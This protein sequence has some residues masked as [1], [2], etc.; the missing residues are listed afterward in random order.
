MFKRS[1]KGNF[2]YLKTKRINTAIITAVFF[3]LSLGIILTGYLTTGTR[4]NLL[5]IVGILGLLPA[6]K[7]LVSLIMLIR[8]KGADQKLFDLINGSDNNLIS[9]YDMYFTSYK[10]NFAVYHMTVK[11]GVII[12][13]SGDPSFD[14]KQCSEHVNA[15][16]KQAGHNGFTTCF[17]TKIDDYL[18]M[19]NSLNEK[20]SLNKDPGRDDGI[21][22]S[23][24]EIIL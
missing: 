23:L 18:K 6:S 13:Y 17:S 12:G 4:K 3:T 14:A 8:A 24:Y 7:S 22:I 19:L 10:K 5:T 20:A 21:R 15:M 9:M 11:E 16:L 1:I 2:Q